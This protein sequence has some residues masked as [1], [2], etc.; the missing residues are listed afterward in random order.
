MLLA[1]AVLADIAPEE[2]QK[3][4]LARYSFLYGESALLWLRRWRNQ[5]KRDV[6]TRRRARA[7]KRSLSELADVLNRGSG[8]R[9]YLAA[10]R[11]PAAGVRADDMEA[12][13]LLWAAVNPVN[14]QAIG[15]AA[16]E[17]YETLSGGGSGAPITAYLELPLEY[18]LAIGDGLSRRDPS[19]WYL[20]ADTAADLREHT[21]PVAGGGEL[22][23]RVA[24]INDVAIHLDTLLPIAPVLEGALIYDWLIRS[25]IVVELNA[26]LD[27]ALGPPPNHPRKVLFSLLDLCRRQRTEAASVE[28]QALRD[29]I[30]AAGWNYIR[31][32]RNLLGAH[33]DD[34]LKM[35][36]IYE[37][38]IYLDYRGVI[39]VAC[40]VLN[41]LDRIGASRLDL[42]FLLIGERIIRSWPVDPSQQAPGRPSRT[43]LTG[44][45]S[46]FFRRLDSPYMA[47]SGSSLG[48]AVLIGIT[49]QR[50][51]EPRP[52]TRI[53]DRRFNRYLEPLWSERCSVPL[54]SP[55]KPR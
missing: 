34:N 46:R 27:L 39:N 38:L 45:L 54:L 52:K 42:E 6:S 43:I 48:S 4:T 47:V 50:K 2:I 8:V 15:A 11:Q 16:V 30:G 49:A 23:S 20:A 17:A 3:R 51:P 32:A 41:R 13:R 35:L 37:H 18:R 44:T 12:T 40:T 19:Y 25:A 21:L 14:V 1:A 24:Q 55:E 53:P 26:L 31:S 9:H 28:L 7:A 33:V 29:D 36:E 5:L 10:K 22:G